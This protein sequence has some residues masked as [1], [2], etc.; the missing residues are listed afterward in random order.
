MWTIALLLIIKTHV[1]SLEAFLL[2]NEI[3][4][5]G[6]F[7]LLWLTEKVFSMIQALSSKYY[8]RSSTGAA[9]SL[10]CMADAPPFPR[11]TQIARKPVRREQRVLR[12]PK[13]R[14]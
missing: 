13:K 10:T 8:L 3:Q 2:Y 6:R 12:T 7:I 11:K 14:V 9:S 4:S 5:F 1:K